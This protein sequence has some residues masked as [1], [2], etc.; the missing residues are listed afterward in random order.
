VLVKL[1]HFEEMENQRIER[2]ILHRRA[3]DFVLK[4]LNYFKDKGKVVP[5]L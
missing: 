3:T 4:M 2:Q 5:V 1:Y